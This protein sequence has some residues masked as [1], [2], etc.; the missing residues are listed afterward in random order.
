MVD[1]LHLPHLDEPH[2]HGLRSS[3]K[4]SLTVVLGLVQHLQQQRG[5]MF[6]PVNLFDFSCFLVEV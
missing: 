5:G 2:P 1:G 4:H 6:H 3:L